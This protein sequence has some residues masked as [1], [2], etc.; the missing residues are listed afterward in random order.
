MRND[1]Q[2]TCTGSPA[3][4]VRLLGIRHASLPAT[5]LL[6]AESAIR[7][8]RLRCQSRLDRYRSCDETHPSPVRLFLN[9]D[10]TEFTFVVD[11]WIKGGDKLPREIGFRTQWC[12][13]GEVMR[14][15]E[16]TFRFWGKNK[17]DLPNAEWEFLHFEKVSEEV[18][19]LII[20]YRSAGV[21]PVRFAMRASMRGPISS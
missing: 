12:T 14:D 19:T 18:G 13:N 3:R 6:D 16:G 17:P 2:T 20:S 8:G 15:D 4:V 11:R 21:R 10:F 5:S 1:D 7:S 9:K